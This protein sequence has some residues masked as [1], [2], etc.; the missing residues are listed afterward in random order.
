MT[1]V[2]WLCLGAGFVV[3]LATGDVS[4]GGVVSHNDQIYAG[5]DGNVCKYEKDEGWSEVGGGEPKFNRASDLPSAGNLDDDRYACDRDGERD[6]NRNPGVHGG[7][8]FGGG[9][10]R[11]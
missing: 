4:K 10:R 3:A 6:F 11:R 9:G 7:G 1:S 5:K 8:G 2:R